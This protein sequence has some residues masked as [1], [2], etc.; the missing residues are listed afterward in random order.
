MFW[1]IL[2]GPEKK[3]DE[4]ETRTKHNSAKDHECQILFAK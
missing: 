2:F 1:K 4:K 3:I